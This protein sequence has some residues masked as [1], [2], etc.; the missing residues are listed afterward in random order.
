MSLAP[1]FSNPQSFIL[2]HRHPDTDAICDA[3]LGPVSTSCDAS[4]STFLWTGPKQG[5]AKERPS[6]QAS[7]RA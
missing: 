3:F 6:S 1:D 7:R 5:G 2:F 4:F